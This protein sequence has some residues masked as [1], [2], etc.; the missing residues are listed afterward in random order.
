[1]N[2]GVHVSFWVMVSSGHM[3]SSGIAGS[4]G[5]FIPSFL[6][7][8]CTVFH[9]DC[10]VYIPTNSSGVFPFF[11]TLYSIYSLYIFWWWP[12]WLDCLFLWYL[13]RL[14][15]S[16]VWAVCIF[17]ILIPCQLLHLQIF[18][19]ILRDVFSSS[20]WFPLLCKSFYIYWV[21]FVYFYFHYSR[22]RIKNDLAAIYIIKC[23]A[24]D[25]L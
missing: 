8:L 24:Y 3:P 5:K 4:Y 13:I 15:V 20:L 1:M 10:I 2:T 9:N 21:L 14:F 11:H 16:L 25:F 22:R 17:C 6:R 18:S 19:P 23:S 12:F 7:N